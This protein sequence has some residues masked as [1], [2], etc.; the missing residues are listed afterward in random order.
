MSSQAASIASQ[1]N[2][3][4]KKKRGG[5]V[6]ALAVCESVCVSFYEPVI[7]LTAS[8]QPIKGNKTT[9][10]PGLQA[11]S[12]CDMQEQAED[13]F[14]CWQS[15]PGT[16]SNPAEYLHR[17][18]FASEFSLFLVYLGGGAVLGATHTQSN[19]AFLSCPLPC[20]MATELNCDNGDEWEVGGE[21]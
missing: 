11:P 18:G 16:T 21:K 7:W 20:P 19:L 17:F 15:A 5:I 9:S 6:E 4:R 2:G 14:L 12:A 3:P 8:S 1:Q 10:N 13:K